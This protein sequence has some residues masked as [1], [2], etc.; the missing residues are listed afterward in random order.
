MTPEELYAAVKEL[1]DS[2]VAYSTSGTADA[3]R[4]A[5]L[6]VILR[7]DKVTTRLLPEFVNSC[8][9]LGQFW[10][11][12]KNKFPTYA[13][14]REYLWGEFRPLL[15]LLEEAPVAQPTPALF[16]GPNALRLFVSHVSTYK[17]RAE[18]LKN[19]LRPFA[20]SAFVAH[21]DIEPT[22]EWVREIE[23]GLSTCDALLALIS[24]DFHDSNWTDQEVGAV[25]GRGKLIIPIRV[26]CDPYGF[27]GQFQGLS[28]KGRTPQDIV[29]DLLRIIARHSRT[30]RVYAEALVST[31]ETASSWD[32]AKRITTAL[33]YFTLID[34]DLRQ[35]IEAAVTNN[36]EVSD[37]RDVPERLVRV[38]ADTTPH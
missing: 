3:E 19:A 33:E 38:C 27:I 26:G 4:Y 5:T 22:A 16:W 25:F 15:D 37:A 36:G 2:L 23:A 29:P 28:A 9:D 12:I 17:M 14:R 32:E 34:A 35:R 10:A 24:P 11:F 13:Q 6:R 18:G 1:Q 21:S 31:L 20:I 8:R 7:R 30:R